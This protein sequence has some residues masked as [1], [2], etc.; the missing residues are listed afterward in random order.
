MRTQV[1]ILALLYTYLYDVRL[2]AVRRNLNLLSIKKIV[3]G[4]HNDHNSVPIQP[5]V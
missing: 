4:R 1:T 5:G 2:N 3:N